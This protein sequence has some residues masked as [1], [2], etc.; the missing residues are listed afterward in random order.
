APIT[1]FLEIETGFEARRVEYNTFTE[2]PVQGT[3]FTGALWRG[4]ASAVWRVTENATFKGTAFG[5][6]NAADSGPMSSS[7]YGLEGALKIDFAPPG[8]EIGMN[9][10]VVPFVRYL[11]I[12]FDS[13]DPLVDPFL[14]RRD[15]QFRVG[16]QLNMPFSST[17]GVSAVAQYDLYNSNIP[18]YRSSG[19]S[20][21]VGPT[22]RF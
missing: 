8:E 14:S 5:G 10:S 16:S 4:Q 22:I 13:P 21:L 6:H 3:L 18:N 9:W 7:H 11:A 2:L 17:L 20:F 15:R 1:N 19:G 12:D